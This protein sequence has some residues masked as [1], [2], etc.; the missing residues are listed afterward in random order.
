M[1]KQSAT[2][3][4]QQVWRQMDR[5][6]RRQA[7]DAMC[8]EPEYAKEKTHA[9]AVLAAKLHLRPQSAARLTP[10]KMAGYLTSIDFPDELLAASLVRAFL[11]TRQ[12]PMLSM[13]LDELQIAHEKGVIKADSVP[14]PSAEA[15]QGAVAKIQGA[16]D[17][18]DV[19]I[20]IAALLA[21]DPET[22]VN[23]EALAT[24]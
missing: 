1:S 24:A 18:A 14:P 6:H 7:A 11:F 15:L 9:A 17:A 12:Q 2:K 5:D 23:L 13:F 4:F 22:W 21:S 8:V 19:K 16:F 10:E 20:Y 3:T